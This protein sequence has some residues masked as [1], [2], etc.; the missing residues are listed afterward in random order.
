ML[1]KQHWNWIK[2]GCSESLQIAEPKA[3][4]VF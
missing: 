2:I 3:G 4:M 1:L